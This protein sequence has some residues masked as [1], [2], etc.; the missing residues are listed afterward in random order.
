MAMSAA[1]K[2]KISQ[3]VKARWAMRRNK[4]ITYTNVV[5]NNNLDEAI[6]GLRTKLEILERAKAIAAAENQTTV[7]VGAEM[8]ALMKEVA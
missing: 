3:T 7:D 5:N 8:K 4:Q 1:T 6:T 2:R